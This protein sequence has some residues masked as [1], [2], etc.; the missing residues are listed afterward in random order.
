MIRIAPNQPTAVHEDLSTR[1]L[2]VSE[3]LRSPDVA[4]REAAV[5]QRAELITEMTGARAGQIGNYLDQQKVF[6]RL[7]WQARTSRNGIVR[8]GGAMNTVL[9]M[10]P[11]PVGRATASASEAVGRAVGGTIGGVAKGTVLGLWRVFF[12]KK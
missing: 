2:S 7:D 11:E 12:K 3:R 1:F 5:Q 6:D 9:G 10:T 8:L 4:V